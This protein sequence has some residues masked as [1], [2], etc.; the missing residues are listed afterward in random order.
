MLFPVGLMVTRNRQQTSLQSKSSTVFSVYANKSPHRE[1]DEG[2]VN[3]DDDLEEGELK[4]DDEP[5]TGQKERSP[6]RFFGKGQCTWGDNCRFSHD[7]TSPNK[8]SGK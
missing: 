2:Q 1:L 7:F 6:C 4:D 5:V 8:Q 3:S